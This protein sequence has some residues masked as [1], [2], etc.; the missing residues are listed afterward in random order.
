MAPG[1]TKN[2]F[3][4][5]VNDGKFHV[6]FGIITRKKKAAKSKNLPLFSRMSLMRVMR[7]LQVMSVKACYGFI[8]DASPKKAG[9][10]KKRKRQNSDGDADA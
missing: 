4:Q 8:T 3:K 7:D 2:A 5:P 10:K 1:A 6:V 9:K